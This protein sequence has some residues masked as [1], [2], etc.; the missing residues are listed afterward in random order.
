MD[1]IR[2]TQPNSKTWI[3]WPAVA[4]VILTSFW[5]LQG[6]ATTHISRDK[7]WLASVTQGD[8][9]LQA[10]GFGVLQSKAQRFL[11][12]PFSAVVEEIRLKPGAL[13]N[14]NSI[15]VRLSNPEIDQNVTTAQMTVNAQKAVM[16]EFQLNFEKEQ[17]GVQQEIQEVTLDLNVAKTRLNAE[18]NLAKEGVV[19]SLD[20]LNSE[21]NVAKLEARLSHLHKRD[22]KSQALFKQKEQIESQKLEEKQSLLS[23]ALNQQARLNV[24]AGIDGVLQALPIELGQSLNIGSQIALVG[25]TD[26]LIALIK[27]PQQE[28]QN[29]AIGHPAI[30]DTRG[31]SAQANVVRIDP[32]VQD[33]HVEVEL[34]LVGDLPSNARPA[35]NVSAVI[36]LGTVAN[37]LT[38][39]VPVNAKA[40]SRVPLYKLSSDQH[41]AELVWVE[42]GKKSGQRIEVLNGAARGD[43]FILS[44]IGNQYQQT[45]IELK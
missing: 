16:A 38:L 20:L 3:T 15:I 5:L 1:K 23:L 11:T 9:S 33:G 17:L 27:V 4:V 34:E 25:N 45:N 2:T 22:R 12:A 43:E 30:V 31:G 35:L 24:T 10:S 32:V 40:N 7:L 29:L 44:D 21:A 37:V 19:S 6:E 8:L 36:E 28:L 18:K 42:L 39:P 14:K 26:S 41:S 13:V